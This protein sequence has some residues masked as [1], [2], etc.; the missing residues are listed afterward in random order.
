M[1]KFCSRFI[2]QIFS[3]CVCWFPFV[4]V[5]SQPSVQEDKLAE[6]TIEIFVWPKNMME[7]ALQEA[8]FRESAQLYSRI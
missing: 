4:I 3:F 5:V 7:T 1:D 6:G 8:D 2:S